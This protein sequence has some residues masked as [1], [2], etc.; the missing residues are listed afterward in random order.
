ME[1]GQ[2]K[3]L[4]ELIENSGDE[5]DLLTTLL[6]DSGYIGNDWYSLYD[7]GLTEAPIVAYGS[8]SEDDGETM[9]YE[10]MWIFNDYNIYNFAEILLKEK[11]VIFKK[12]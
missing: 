1:S 11:K 6:D 7:V 9:D 5:R 4:K 12:V 8:W 3:E 10:Q 2:K